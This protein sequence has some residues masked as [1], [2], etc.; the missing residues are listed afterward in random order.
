MYI[1]PL[2]NDLEQNLKK[3]DQQVGNMFEKGKRNKRVWELS[4]AR[5]Q[6]A[7]CHKLTK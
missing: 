2:Q 5:V 7:K 4:S 3:V 1:H 6:A